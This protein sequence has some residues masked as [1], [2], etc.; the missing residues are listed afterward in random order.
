M[1]FMNRGIYG[2]EWV[3]KSTTRCETNLHARANAVH[4]VSAPAL[5]QAR[6]HT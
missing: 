4:V 3:T 6:F 2:Q 1:N 5:P